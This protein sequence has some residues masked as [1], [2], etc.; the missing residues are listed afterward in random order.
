M[1]NFLRKFPFLVQLNPYYFTGLYKQAYHFRFY[2]PQFPSTRNNRTAVFCG[3]TPIP[4]SS[5]Q[6]SI[7]DVEAFVTSILNALDQRHIENQDQKESGALTDI[8]FDL[9]SV[10]ERY[11]CD[12]TFNGSFNI[13]EISN[14]RNWK[15]HSISLSHTSNGQFKIVQHTLPDLVITEAFTRQAT[16]ERQMQIFVDVL[17]QLKEFYNNLS[18]IDELCYVVYPIHIDTRTS[19]RIFKY[20]QKVFLKIVLHPLQPSSIDITF[21]GPTRLVSKLREKYNEKQEEWDTESRVYTNL[22]RIFDIISF[23]IRPMQLAGAERS[24]DG[25]DACGICMVYKDS[26]NRIPFISCDNEK[27]SLIFHV[28]CLKEK[29]SKQFFT[30]SIGNCPYCKQKISSSFDDLI[31]SV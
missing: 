7:C 29:E 6:V 15:K 19:W 24:E 16:L 12:V 25:D 28:S 3:S 22:V 4:L 23:P 10:Q 9:L 20:D 2:F 30:V 18:M 1:E 5:D 17:D 31:L 27:C 21:I 8:A 13:V 14:L 26:D 11:Q